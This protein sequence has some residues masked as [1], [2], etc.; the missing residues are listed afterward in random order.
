M[1]V[2]IDNRPIFDHTMGDGIVIKDKRMAIGHV[3][4]CIGTSNVTTFVCDG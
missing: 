2:T 3:Y 1:V 4:L